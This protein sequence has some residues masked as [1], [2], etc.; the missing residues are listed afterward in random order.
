MPY[1]FTR[2]SQT[3]D[4]SL[5]D[6][7]PYGKRFFGISH[8]TDQVRGTRFDFIVMPGIYRRAV[9]LPDVLRPSGYLPWKP[10]VR[11]CLR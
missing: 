11:G 8:L 4:L 2:L 7:G 6:W 9:A 3:H 5:P 1:D 10:C